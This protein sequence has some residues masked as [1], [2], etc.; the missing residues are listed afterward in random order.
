[1]ITIKLIF[2]ALKVLYNMLCVII[3]FVFQYKFMNSSDH[4]ITQS[5]QHKPNDNLINNGLVDMESNSIV[6]KA[7]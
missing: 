6:I 1:M 3:L 7:K 4:I 2:L 5:T